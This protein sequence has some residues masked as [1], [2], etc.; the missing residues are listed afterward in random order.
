MFPGLKKTKQNNRKPNP[1][2]YLE[3][4]AERSRLFPDPVHSQSQGPSLKVL[5][6]L[7]CRKEKHFGEGVG[8]A[9]RSFLSSL[10]VREFVVGVGVSGDE[11]QLRSPRCT[12]RWRDQ[13]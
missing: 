10:Y 8:T 7:K 11:P 2:V 3:G 4:F 1:C 9:A 13:V 6:K 5:R 12:S